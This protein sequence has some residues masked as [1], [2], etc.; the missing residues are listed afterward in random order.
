MLKNIPAPHCSGK[1]PLELEQG[2][3][4]VMGLCEHS[5]GGTVVFFS[6]SLSLE[7]KEKH[8][9]RIESMALLVG[10]CV[11]TWYLFTLASVY[12]WADKMQE[13]RTYLAR[14]HRLLEHE[15]NNG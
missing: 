15:I 2:K 11:C 9:K 7:M 8:Q 3:L 4:V 1:S 10:V 14:P 5:G 6:L 12:G 13:F